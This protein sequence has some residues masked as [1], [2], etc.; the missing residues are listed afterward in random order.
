MFT[1]ARLDRLPPYVFATVNEIK[2]EARRSG[3]DIIDLG[4][5]N[6]GLGFGEY[7]DEYVRFALIENP[8]RI[9]QAIRGIRKIVQSNKTRF[10]LSAKN[11]LEI[12][13]PNIKIRNSNVQKFGILVIR[14]SYLF[15]I[16]RF[17]FRIFEATR[18][19]RIHGVTIAEGE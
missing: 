17:V 19:E 7:G 2:M 1:F 14:H 5:G 16:W 10:F 11:C 13:N 6:P 4:M 18:I 12:L 15:G 3:K 8:M 9:N